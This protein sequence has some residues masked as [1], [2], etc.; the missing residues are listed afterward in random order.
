[1]QT[2]SGYK[3]PTYWI[4]AVVVIWIFL[5]VQICYN[6]GRAEARAQSDITPTSEYVALESALKTKAPKS[7][8]TKADFSSIT[9]TLRLGS[10]G[11][12]VVQWQK[13]LNSTKNYVVVD[14][15]FGK[16]THYATIGW[17]STKN[18]TLDGVV[19]ANTISCA[20]DNICLQNAT[21]TTD[22]APRSRS[23]SYSYSRSYPINSYYSL[24]VTWYY[25]EFYISY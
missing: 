22:S 17:Q 18:L 9:E 1:M 2:E 7:K 23:F 10:S 6:K 25:E 15:K 14:G 8:E 16:E 13:F 5:I 20:K 21:Y 11:D 3:D 24:E 4:L 12:G 19:G